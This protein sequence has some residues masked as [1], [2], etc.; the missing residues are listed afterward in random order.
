MSRSVHPHTRVA[1]GRLTA[2]INI[3]SA[4]VRCFAIA[5]STI[6]T[7]TSAG[8]R[9]LT[10]S[11]LDIADDGLFAVVEGR[12][13]GTGRASGLSCVRWWKPH[14]GTVSFFAWLLY[15]HMG[16]LWF[17]N[18][19]RLLSSGIEITRGHFGAE[20]RNWKEGVYSGK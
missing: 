5:N 10:G 7:A 6:T 8:L 19:H 17:N 18:T 2:L 13:R 16:W 15:R 12:T 4:R 11:M 9:V 3:L 20:H 14:G 1:N